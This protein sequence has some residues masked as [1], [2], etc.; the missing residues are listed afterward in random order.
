M[1]DEEQSVIQQP[2]HSSPFDAIREVNEHG[3]E[4]WSALKLSKIL[5]YDDYRN[6]QKV[7]SKAIKSC[8]SSGEAASD[9]FVEVT[10]MIIVGKG[11]RGYYCKRFCG[12]S[13]FWL[14][15]ALWRTFCPGD[16]RAERIA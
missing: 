16:S 13:R 7:V 10:D 5:T 12:F 15:R 9:H 1:K 2:Q 4:Y 14:Q 3:N 8:E 6:F 11:A